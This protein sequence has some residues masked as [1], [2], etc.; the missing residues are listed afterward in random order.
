MTKVL[1]AYFIFFLHSPG[2][3]F[4]IILMEAISF[5]NNRLCADPFKDVVESIFNCRC[6]RKSINNGISTY[7]DNHGLDSVR[8]LVGSLSLN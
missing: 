4:S 3:L 5:D 1:V 6:A 2:H 7:L 8:S